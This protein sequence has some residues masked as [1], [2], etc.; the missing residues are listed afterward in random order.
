MRQCDGLF[1]F[2]AVT[3]HQDKLHIHRIGMANG[4]GRLHPLEQH[5]ELAAKGI[6]TGFELAEIEH[7]SLFYNERIP[8]MLVAELS[9][10]GNSAS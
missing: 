1:R 10:P 8:T 3:V 4:D 2:A 6:G 9:A 5:V 7:L